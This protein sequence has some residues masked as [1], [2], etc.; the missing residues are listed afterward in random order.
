MNK[1][2]FAILTSIASLISSGAVGAG[3]TTVI[4]SE[5]N[6]DTFAISA[7]NEPNETRTLAFPISP[8]Q[9]PP[10]ANIVKCRLC[11]V[12]T[13]QSTLPRADQDVDVYWGANQ[14][15]QWSTFGQ[16]TEA[17]V[18]ELM[19][20]AST[21]KGEE[22]PLALKLQT[23]SRH[24]KWEYYGGGAANTGHRPR[25]IVT[26]NWSS[27]ARS[28]RSTDRAYKKFTS[29]SSSRLGPNNGEELLTNPVFYKGKMYAVVGSRD[30]S[31][32]LAGSEKEP[33]YP[34]DFEVDKGSFAC[35]TAWG[36]L[37][38]ITKDAIH[39]YDLSDPNNPPRAL[40]PAPKSE[41]ISIQAGDTPAMGP[42]G[43]LYFRNVEAQGSIVAYNPPLQ[44]IWR[45]DLKFTAVSPITLSVDG[46]YAY[47]L[48]EI[49]PE[50]Q[51][52]AKEIVLVR[53]E[54]ATG[55]LVPKPKDIEYPG[56]VKPLLTELLQPAVVRKYIDK[57]I[58][59]Y[60]FVAGNTNDTGI[61]QL[62]AFDQS[63]QSK[64]V[65]SRGG[66]VATAPVPGVKDGNSL[67]VVQDGTLKRY[68]W[69]NTKEGSAGAYPDS[70]MKV[71]TLKE[72]IS[73]DKITLLVDGS[74]SVYVCEPNLLYAYQS[75]LQT[76]SPEQKLEFDFNLTEFLF[77][78]DGALIGYDSSNVYDL[79]PEEG[80]SS[81]L[82]TGTIDDAN[83]TNTPAGAVNDIDHDER[84]FLRETVSIEGFPAATG[85]CLDAAERAEERA[86]DTMCACQAVVGPPC[87]C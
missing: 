38:I 43:S 10:D 26:Y 86:T 47:A 32:H 11:I 74:D 76:M 53:M 67:F 5:H 58:V 39:S 27:P 45:T 63:G 37:Q 59:D 29:F 18:T 44:E 36:R 42:D 81:I 15:G 71:E 24:T 49:S 12:P 85:H 78:P 82:N 23:E 46:H 33:N 41:K 3:I 64:V 51:T 8:V 73:G 61:L 80:S 60:V 2:L 62:I 6:Q 77:T 70:G 7:E 69:H 22:W 75:A 56:G 66:K 35:V 87:G 1:T 9:F 25:L 48:A 72:G 31:V 57:S 68:L 40:P 4:L 84:R 52:V 17:Y 28:G 50:S 13:Q 79:S 55:E 16:A 34:L 30:G 20:K 54:T 14:M 21:P 83:S 65:W 19:L